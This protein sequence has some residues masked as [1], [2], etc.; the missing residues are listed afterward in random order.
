[1]TLTSA[2]TH[3]MKYA[4]QIVHLFEETMLTTPYS[5]LSGGCLR[6]G[7][8]DTISS[9]FLPDFLV[10]FNKKFPNVKMSLNNGLYSDLTEK[11]HAFELD[12]AF[13]YGQHKQ[14]NLDTVRIVEEELVLISAPTSASVREF[15]TRPLLV[16]GRP[17]CFYQDTMEQ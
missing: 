16:T 14:S 4:E 8:Q 11:I 3:L 6:I 13:V 1:M 5:E 17:G 7:S 15:L 12:V 2:G 10:S 9:I